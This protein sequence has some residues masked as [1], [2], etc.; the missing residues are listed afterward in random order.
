MGAR[1]PEPI[2]GGHIDAKGN[3]WRDGQII[4]NLKPRRVKRHDH[5]SAMR[6]ALETAIE[7]AIEALD[8]LDGEPDLEEGGDLEPNLGAL[9]RHPNLYSCGPGLYG[10]GGWAVSA[11]SDLEADDEVEPN[12]GAPEQVDQTR[13]SDSARMTEQDLEEQCEDEGG[14][15]EDEGADTGDREPDTDHLCH[16]QD[17]GDQTHLIAH[18]TFSKRPADVRPSWANVGELVPVSVRP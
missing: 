17:E 5:R 3:L 16:W 6:R 11:S 1:G 14:A 9:E 4:A 13:W 12:L 7:T 15:C 8:R 2:F 18:R 10:Q